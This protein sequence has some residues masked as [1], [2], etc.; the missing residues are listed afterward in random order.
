MNTSPDLMKSQE[1]REHDNKDRYRE[2]KMHIKV[3]E[4]E[5]IGLFDQVKRGKNSRGGAYGIQKPNFILQKQKYQ[6]SQLDPIIIR[7]SA[8]VHPNHSVLRK[9]ELM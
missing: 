7:G 9:K 5:R 1:D 8:H 6:H 2:G 3:S 4:K